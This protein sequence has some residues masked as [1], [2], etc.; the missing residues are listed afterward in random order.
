MYETLNKTNYIDYHYPLLPRLV[1]ALFEMRGIYSCA[2]II[3]LS[4]VFDKYYLIMD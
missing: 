3:S 2:N 1:G 4:F